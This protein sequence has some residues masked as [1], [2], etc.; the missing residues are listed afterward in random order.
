MVSK[1]KVNRFFPIGTFIRKIAKAFHQLLFARNEFKKNVKS[2]FS[3]TK[4]KYY[5]RIAYFFF[6]KMS[7]NQLEM[8]WK[9]WEEIYGEFDKTDYEDFTLR[10]LP[11]EA[12][13]YFGE[14]IKW[15]Q[16]INPAPKRVLL[17]G[18]NNNTVRHLQPEFRVEH[19]YTSGLSN[20]DYEWNYEN[21]PPQMG[22]FDLI[23][24]QAIL[25]HLLNPYKHMYDLASLL[26]P[27]GYL[28]VPKILDIITY[29]ICTKNQ[30]ISL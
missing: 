6:R 24:S 19:I 10:G 25:E 23:I 30:V 22:S 12:K 1:K 3:R 29:F 21:D 5:S 2:F 9:K 27:G 18:E 7:S 28:I 8:E 4:E 26:I 20:V 17:A 11:N 15:A 13:F 14:I 16:D